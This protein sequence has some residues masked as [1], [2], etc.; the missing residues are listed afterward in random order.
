M[1]KTVLDSAV[2]AELLLWENL[3]ELIIKKKKKVQMPAL[4]VK[5]LT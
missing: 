1:S 2:A 3:D 4:N 5:C